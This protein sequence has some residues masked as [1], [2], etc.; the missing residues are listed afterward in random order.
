MYVCVCVRVYVCVRE[1]EERVRVTRCCL[2]SVCAIVA[3]IYRYI[4]EIVLAMNCKN[5]I[6]YYKYA[7]AGRY[8]SLGGFN[9][10]KYS[11][12]LTTNE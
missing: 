7:I 1:R 2:Y 9:S 10:V 8:L 12:V 11:L 5:I 4:S 6:Q 3:F